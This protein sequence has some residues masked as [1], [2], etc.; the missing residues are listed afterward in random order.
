L[1]ILSICVSVIE[2]P[3]DAKEGYPCLVREIIHVAFAYYKSFF[4]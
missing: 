2:V 4:I 1:N 3:N